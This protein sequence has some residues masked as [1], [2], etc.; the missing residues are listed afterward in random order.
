MI[1][2]RQHFD[3]HGIEIV[4]GDLVNPRDPDHAPEEE[5]CYDLHV[6][7]AIRPP[8]SEARRTPSA[9][10]ELSPNNAVRIETRERLTIPNG[11]FGQICSRASLT[12]EGLVVSNLKVDPNFQ[13]RLVVTVF[14]TS[15]NRIR[16]DSALPFCS[17]F[18]HTLEES[19]ASQRVRTPPEARAITESPWK[20]GLRKSFPYVIT[21]VLSVVAS[22]IAAGVVDGG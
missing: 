5:I 16:I 13:G 7:Q 1:I 6:G 14:N 17:V 20:V 2:Q 8:G 4:D 19:L 9:H 22:L 3:R 11:V 12:A 15:K 18:F 10:I 21:F